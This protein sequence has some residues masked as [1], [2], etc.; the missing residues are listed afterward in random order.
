MS[1]HYILENL[2][3]RQLHVSVQ[4]TYLP[5][6]ADK[7]KNT[8]PFPRFSRIPHMLSVLSWLTSST[9]LHFFLFVRVF[10]L[11]SRYHQRSIHQ[12][13]AIEAK[14]RLHQVSLGAVHGTSRECSCIWCSP[15]QHFL[16][17]LSFWNLLKSKCIQVICWARTVSQT[18]GKFFF[19]I[20]TDQDR[21]IFFS[22]FYLFSQKTYN[23]NCFD[24]YLVC[25][26]VFKVELRQERSVGYL[27]YMRTWNSFTYIRCCSKS[28]F[29][30][31][32]QKSKCW[33]LI[34]LIFVR[35]HFYRY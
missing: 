7:P 26:R 8:D 31:K 11:F 25:T 4:T 1:P 10:L 32:S 18:K 23:K 20:C 12:P 34:S 14:P 6:R 28:I 3:P 5:L 27:L 13:T 24:K 30:S 16:R 17:L 19:A 29:Y 35:T 9:A 2:T 15:Q 21:K 33:I 22:C